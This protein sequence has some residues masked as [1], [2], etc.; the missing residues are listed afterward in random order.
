MG[1]G[2]SLDT[3]TRGKVA[4]LTGCNSETIRY[5]ER[6]GLLP[7]PKRADNGYRH[8]GEDEVSRLRFIN[9][10]KKLGFSNNEVRELL[11]ISV[12]PGAHT[13]AEV[14]ALTKDHID[15]IKLR[16]SELKKIEKSLTR[17][18]T[19]CDGADERADLCPILLSLFEQNN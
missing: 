11:G 3:L 1:E 5:Y 19:Q 15:S 17:V 18:Y 4:D 16:I 14:K 9:K 6:I 2:V 12:G 7:K 8:Y 13:R 10:A